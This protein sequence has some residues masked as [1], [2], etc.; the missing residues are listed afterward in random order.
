M[1]EWS[2]RF[3]NNKS[4]LLGSW[5]EEVEIDKMPDL[6]KERSIKH[7]VFVGALPEPGIEFSGNLRFNSFTTTKGDPMWS[8]GFKNGDWRGASPPTST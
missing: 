5:D 6:I 8:I 2:W 4:T 1:I 3:E 7:V